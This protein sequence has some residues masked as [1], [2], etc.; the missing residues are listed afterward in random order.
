M[1]CAVGPNNDIDS[2]IP[3]ATSEFGG[4]VITVLTGGM[5]L[6]VSLVVGLLLTFVY[7]KFVKQS[8]PATMTG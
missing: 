4:F 2:V 7:D 6:G 5:L 1:G 3:K 8:E